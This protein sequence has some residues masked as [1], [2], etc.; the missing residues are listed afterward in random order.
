MTY[1][2]YSYYLSSCKVE[3]YFRSKGY[4]VDTLRV[5]IKKHL[6]LSS[7][8]LKERLEIKDSLLNAKM[9]YSD[10]ELFDLKTKVV[11]LFNFIEEQNKA[12]KRALWWYVSKNVIFN[13]TVYDL[14][15]SDRS[16]NDKL[17]GK[18]E[19]RYRF[20]KILKD[21]IESLI[22]DKNDTDEFGY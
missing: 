22:D 7:T 17:V 11:D 13:S 19:M 1:D 8:E 14:P 10:E 21:Y 16:R 2:N 4:N 20:K 12:N 9:V 5:F 6:N 3:R 15:W 18:Y